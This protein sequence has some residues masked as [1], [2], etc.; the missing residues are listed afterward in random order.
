M[1]RLRNR[2]IDVK[3][4]YRNKYNND[5]QCHL[6]KVRE[7]SQ[8]HLIQCEIILSDSDVKESIGNISYNDMFSTNPSTQ[9]L[10][11]NTWQKVLKLREIILKYQE[12]SSYQASPDLSGASYTYNVRNWI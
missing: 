11:V 7:E 9:K 6:C 8:I 5:V 1:F 12:Q 4:N 2:L 3:T 10:V